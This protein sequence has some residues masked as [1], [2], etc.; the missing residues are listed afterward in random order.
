MPI[1]PVLRAAHVR[2]TPTE[3]FRLFT[4]HIGSWWPLATHGLFGGKAGGL[5]FEDGRLV[6]RS[7]TGETTVWAEVEVW[8][9]PTRLV[10]A[11]HPGR[12]EGPASRVEVCFTG[13]VDGTRVELSHHGWEAFGERAL[14][15]RG[16]Y[17]G[18]GTWGSVLDQFADVADR[19]VSAADLADLVAAYEAFFAEASA[20]G[21][22]APDSGE[23]TAEQVVAHVATNDDVLAAVCRSLVHGAEPALDNAPAIDAAALDAVVAAHGSMTALVALGRRRAETFRLLVGRLDADQLAT[24]VRCHLV[25]G[26]TVVVDEPI[27]WAGVLA[28][29][30]RFHLPLH[31]TQLASLRR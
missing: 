18:S 15:A 8:E 1:A 16:D 23:W 25:D 10:L 26:T 12:T 28:T 14:G 9:P 21:F 30:A 29:Q 5:A 19:D 6:E 13:D 20:G 11:W 27:P 7:L 17:S 3:T 2:R 31:T 22:G 4:E 24:A